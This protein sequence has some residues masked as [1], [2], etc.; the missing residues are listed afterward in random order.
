MFRT[1]IFNE[2]GITTQTEFEDSEYNA[3]LS[4]YNQVSELYK[5]YKAYNSIDNSLNAAQANLTSVQ[6]RNNNL[7]DNSARIT[8]LE[9]FVSDI[10]TALADSSTGIL[11][12]ITL[13]NAREEYV[14]EKEQ[15][16]A[17]QTAQDTTEIEARITTLTS[18]LAAQ[19]TV[20]NDLCAAM[21]MGDLV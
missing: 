3:L 19:A 16:E 4:Q 8:E 10:D 15:L 1:N 2:L 7:P 14:T 9:G 11:D 5:E 18:E 21:G 17:E 20:V 6:E 13:Q 12:K